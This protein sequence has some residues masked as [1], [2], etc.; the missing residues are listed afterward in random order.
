MNHN[1][2]LSGSLKEMPIPDVRWIKL[3][4]ARDE[5]GVL[6]AVE[7]DKDIPFGVK[8]IFYMYGTPAGVERGGHAHRFTQ[9]VIVAVNGAF[10]LDVSDGE[11]TQSF[12]LNNPND[13]LYL[14]PMTWTRLYD[15]SPAT[16]VLVLADTHYE[17]SHS[18]RT[19]SEF[20][21]AV[22]AL[23]KTRE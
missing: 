18:L 22:E 4:H 23:R 9:Q 12:E 15:F 6:T 19:W 14:P 3:P 10:R 11:R 20:V 17:R 21:A 2:L 13:G 16:V 7:A 8:R 1:E 5:R